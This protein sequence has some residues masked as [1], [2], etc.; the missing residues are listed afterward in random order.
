MVTVLSAVFL[1][2]F[3]ATAWA[4]ES[5]RDANSGFAKAEGTKDDGTTTFNLIKDYDSVNTTGTTANPKSN[6]PAETV[7]YTIK[8][9]GVWNAGSTYDNIGTATPINATNMPMFSGSPGTNGSGTGADRTWS[10]T[11]NLDLGDAKVPAS[12]E[13]S[14]IST[15]N[16]TTITL[17]T[18]DTVGDYWYEVK[19]TIGVNEHPTTGVIYGTNDA[20]SVDHTKRNDN[21]NATYY[22]HVQVTDKN[23]ST[24]NKQL[25]SNVTLHKTPPEKNWENDDYNRS[26]VSKYV[27]SANDKVNAIENTYYAG[28]LVITKAV[29][30]NASDKSQYFPVKVIFTKPANTIVNSDITFSAFLKSEDNGKDVYTKTPITI[31]GQ[32]S[33]A[34]ETNSLIRWKQGSSTTPAIGTYTDVTTVT[35]EFFV[36]DTDTVT[37]SN[38][39]YG[40]TYTVEETLPANDTYKNKLE[41]TDIDVA[42]SFGGI[43]LE[44][45]KNSIGLDETGT[46]KAEGS[47][48]DAQDEITITNQKNMTI[49]IGVITENGPFVAL[50]L[51]AGVALVLLVARKK[52]FSEV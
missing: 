42:A 24:G 45:D 31:K 17:P 33:D 41:F 37:F 18:Y 27:S 43:S 44:A 11:S 36:K 12:T 19:E 14:W 26:E 38:I 10:V 47:I 51:V 15:D 2:S 48:S 8:P 49:D 23:T 52:K 6:S 22:L 21:H 39:P 16:K 4:A 28:D 1:L 34:T 7:T 29:A 46:K 35:V 30:G 40:I 25:I 13:D 50:I 5:D 3:T 9:Y 32:Y 20:Q